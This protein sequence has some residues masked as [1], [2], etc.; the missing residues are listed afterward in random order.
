MSLGK[1]KIEYHGQTVFVAKLDVVFKAVFL[2]NG[3]YALLASLLSSILNLSLD[4]EDLQVLNI[5]LAP[6]R[7]DGKIARLDIRI[8][9]SD[10]KHINLE[11]Q[12]HNEQNIAKRSIFHLS[13]LFTQQLNAGMRYNDLSPAIVICIL[14]FDYL[15][16]EEYHNRY[17]I[18]N[19]RTGDV[20]TDA[21]QMDFMELTKAPLGMGNDMKDMWM[22]FLSAKSEEE[23]DMLAEKSPIMSKAVKRLVAVSA[24]EQL[25]YEIDM[26]EKAELDYNSAMQGSYDRGRDEGIE[27]GRDEGIEIGEQ[28]GGRKRALISAERALRRGAKAEDVA[29]DQELPLSV[30]L[31]IKNK[32]S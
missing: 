1:N 8:K 15:K 20:L 19:V 4:A 5:E 27:I 23:L 12:L 31:E 18:A 29:H 24:D 2:S 11:I 13:K 21:F 26:R 30:V 9:T 32:I 22:K 16:Y 25:R 28:R 6:E 14:D 3:D 7:K 10:S 17:M